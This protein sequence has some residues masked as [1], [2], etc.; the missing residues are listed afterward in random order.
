MMLFLYF[1]WKNQV[2]LVSIIIL[3]ITQY[4]A[5]TRAVSAA[6]RV[7]SASKRLY[8]TVL[9]SCYFSAQ[10]YF[11]QYH[12]ILI[13]PSQYSTASVDMYTRA[14]YSSGVFFFTPTK[15]I[16]VGRIDLCKGTKWS[17]RS[18]LWMIWTCNVVSPGSEQKRDR[19]VVECCCGYIYVEQKI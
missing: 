1:Y 19:E 2:S 5:K 4:R 7:H 17:P 15:Q 12:A 6:Y 8:C 11:Y 13:T 14:M 3:Y 18:R 9:D 10:L 16:I